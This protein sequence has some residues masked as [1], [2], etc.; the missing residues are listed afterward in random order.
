MINHSDNKI[1]FWYVHGWDSSQPVARGVLEI[2][3]VLAVEVGVEVRLHRRQIRNESSMQRLT[4]DGLGT[5]LDE[6]A[7]SI[8]VRRLEVAL[9]R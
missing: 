3:P 6:H 5:S 4:N 7:L 9:G 8:G 1:K 2:T